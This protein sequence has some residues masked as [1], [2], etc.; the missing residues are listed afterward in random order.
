M[1]AERWSR[2]E[3]LYHAAKDQEEDQR[4]AFLER[5]CAGDPALRVEVESLIVSAR[6]TG[7]IIDKP[8]LEVVA[9]ALARDLG[10]EAGHKTDKMIGAR[11]AQY[12]IVEKLGAGGMGDV[13]RAVCADDSSGREARSSHGADADDACVRAP[14]A[15]RD[16]L[17]LWK[18]ADPDIPILKLAKAEYA[19]LQ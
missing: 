6:Q 8:A 15:Y 12:R 11:I 16:F 3:Q 13:Y 2:V 18:D 5:S 10:A 17:T 7:Q 9:A 1:Q 19:R 4:A 14:A